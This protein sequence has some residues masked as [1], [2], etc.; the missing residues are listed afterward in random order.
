MK[1]SKKFHE[2]LNSIN[3]VSKKSIL[4]IGTVILLVM[5]LNASTD[6]NPIQADNETT[7][8]TKDNI[9]Q[10]FE[11]QVKTTKETY[12]GTS[13]S[14]KHAEKMVALSSSGEI[15]IGKEIKSFF[16]LRSEMNTK[17]NYFWEVET[18]TGFAK[19]YAS[20]EDYA[21]KMVQLVASGE[22]VLTKIIISQP[23]Q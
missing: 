16:V 6:N 15:V 10:V 19:G 1:I 14:L 5:N 2:H 17:R 3:D 20:T 9:A 7:E 22:P 12:S 8:I 21:R 18:A 11:W 4:I 13:L 23:Q